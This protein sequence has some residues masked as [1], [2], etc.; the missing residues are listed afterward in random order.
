M[1]FDESMGSSV[2]EEWAAAVNAV[3]KQL[4]GNM[5]ENYSTIING[6]QSPPS[7]VNSGADK[8]SMSSC[9]TSTDAR[10]VNTPR[11]EPV[12]EIKFNTFG[13]SYKDKLLL[14]VCLLVLS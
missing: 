14:N 3:A 9:G 8:R 11:G 2:N 6:H 10:D 12:R 7:R 4:T 13:I 5:T 1:S